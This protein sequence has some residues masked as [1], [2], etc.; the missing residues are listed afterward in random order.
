MAIQGQTL[1]P[2][3]WPPSP[4]LAPWAILICSS[5]ALTRYSLVTPKRPEATCLIALCAAVAVGVGLN[6]AGSSPPSPVLL[7]PPSRFMAMASVSCASADDRA[8]RH[9][10]GRKPLDDR[11]DRLDL[12]DRHRRFLSNRNSNRP[13]RV[14]SRSFWSSTRSRV[15]LEDLVAAGLRGVLELV[16]G[17]GVEQVVFAV[18]P[19]LV[20]APLRASAGHRSRPA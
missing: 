17:L 20:L 8:V 3:S 11:L 2:G 16:D 13:R 5:S 14:Q 10:A 4:G 9:R 1:W 6:R 7:L 18:A 15:L 19:P 12:L